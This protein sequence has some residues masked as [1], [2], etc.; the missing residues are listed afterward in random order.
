M[1]LKSGVFWTSWIPDTKILGGDKKK[2]M[3]SKKQKRLPPLKTY[4]LNQTK[5]PVN[6]EDSNKHP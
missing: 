3:N 2:T 4:N 6:L 1:L 5:H